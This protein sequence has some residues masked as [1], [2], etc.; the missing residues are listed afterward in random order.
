VLFVVEGDHNYNNSY[1]ACCVVWMWC[2]I[3]CGYFV[4]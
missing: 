3:V 2:S 4:S 1:D